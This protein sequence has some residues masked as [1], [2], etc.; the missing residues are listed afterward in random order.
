MTTERPQVSLAGKYSIVQAARILGVDRKT[1][2]RKI[3][4]GIIAFTTRADNG[5]K[6]ISGRE[7]LKYWEL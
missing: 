2:S 7:I 3:T 6:V 1:I 5:R 4:E